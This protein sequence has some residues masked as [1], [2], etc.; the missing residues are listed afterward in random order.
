MYLLVVPTPSAAT[1][2][3]LLT[4]R[5]KYRV[6]STW[7]RKITVSP[8]K[9]NS[10]GMLM[11]RLAREAKKKPHGAKRTIENSLDFKKIFGFYMPTYYVTTKDGRKKIELC[12][13][14]VNGD[15]R[16]NA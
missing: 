4:G 2:E 3:R 6:V 14:A 11:K 10:I 7:K 8:G 1:L 12:I 16:I 9:Y 5:D 15:V 13:N